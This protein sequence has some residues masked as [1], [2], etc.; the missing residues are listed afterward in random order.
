MSGKGAGTQ[1]YV[2]VRFTLEQAVVLLALIEGSTGA[3]T[4]DKKGLSRL[5]LAAEKL[6]AGIA[7]PVTV[8]IN[9]R[10]AET[11]H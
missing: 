10:Q 9:K 6:R 7:S 3:P 5:T 11:T 1:R 4:L 2:P 8:A